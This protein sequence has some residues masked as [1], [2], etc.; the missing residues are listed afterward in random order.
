MDVDVDRATGHQ[1]P[2]VVG[3][4]GRRQ[5]SVRDDQQ[6]EVASWPRSSLGVRAEDNDSLR[7]DAIG[8]HAGDR[9]DLF[10][11]QHHPTT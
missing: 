3:A 8:D 10:V 1:R 9:L 7:L 5:R 6:I 11:A 4:E 2:K